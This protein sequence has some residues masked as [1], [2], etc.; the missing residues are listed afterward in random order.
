MCVC[1]FFLCLLIVF[2]NGRGCR[3]AILCSV[4]LVKHANPFAKHIEIHVETEKLGGCRSLVCHPFTL[5]AD[6]LNAQ[7]CIASLF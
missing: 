2:E 6:F 3:V 5:L 7:E 1:V 4:A